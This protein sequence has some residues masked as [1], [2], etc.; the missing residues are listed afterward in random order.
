MVAVSVVVPTYRRGRLVARTIEGLRSVEP[1]EGGFEVIV[2]DDGSDADAIAQAQRAVDSLECARLLTQENRGPA[3]ARNAGVRAS[4]ASLVAFLDDDCIPAP[5]WLNRLIAPF[6][7]GDESLGATGGR[8]LPAESQ[9]WVA[10][11]CAVTEYSSGVQPEFVNAATA[12]ACYRR[13]VLDE[14]EGFDET[15]TLPG[16]DD[17]DLSARALAAGYRLEFVPHAIVH[18]A[19]LESYRD[20]IR[21]MFGRGIGEARLAAKQERVAR[22][23]ARAVLLPAFLTRTAV[24]CWRR[25]SG[26]G[27]VA[28]RSAWVLLESVGRVAFIAG[29]IVGLRQP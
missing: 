10:H 22:V 5:G 24:G 8:V 29:S 12:N 25:T 11:F 7:T 20:F 21:H 16:G 18:H 6:E 9:N 28:E 1:P 13:S 14:L 19:E 15:F 17:P 26:K 3:A 4:S 27:S 23:V 2:V